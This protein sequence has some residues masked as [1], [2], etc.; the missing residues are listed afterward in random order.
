M[1]GL[2]MLNERLVDV[3]IAY[4]TINILILPNLAFITKIQNQDLLNG[5]RYYTTY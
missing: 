2:L 5:R 4:I 1:K 3:E